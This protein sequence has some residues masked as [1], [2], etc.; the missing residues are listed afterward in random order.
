M[1]ALLGVAVC[2]MFVQM[3]RA[4]PRRPAVSKGDDAMSTSPTTRYVVVV[5]P[6]GDT[7]GTLAEFFGPFFAAE[8]AADVAGRWNHDHAGRHAGQAGVWV[9]TVRPMRGLDALR[10]FSPAALT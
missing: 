1:T 9:A 10:G 5:A 6:V 7:D 3:V 4:L 8:Q 2:A